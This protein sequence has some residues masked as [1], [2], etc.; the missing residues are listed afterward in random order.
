M[1]AT[2]PAIRDRGNGGS[3]LVVNRK[4]EEGLFDAVEKIRKARSCSPE[5]AYG[6][7]GLDSPACEI[8]FV[9]G[10]PERVGMLPSGKVGLRLAV[11]D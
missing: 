5:A 7:A 1:D 11:P 2:A 6:L 9:T 8:G 4:S 10:D 3:C